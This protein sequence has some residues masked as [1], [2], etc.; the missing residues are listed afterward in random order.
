[1][2]RLIGTC[3]HIVTVTVYK[4]FG[5]YLKFLELIKDKQADRLRL[6]GLFVLVT[7][8]SA[9]RI[10]LDLLLVLFHMAR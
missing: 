5:S 3:T 1:M 2:L 7:P 8:E 9:V 4:V 6:F 10:E